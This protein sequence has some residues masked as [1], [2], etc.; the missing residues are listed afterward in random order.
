[1]EAKR[2]V[3]FALVEREAQ[4]EAQ[5]AHGRVVAQAKAQ[6]VLQLEAQIGRLREDVPC[7]PEGCQA[8][9]AGVAVA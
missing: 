7:V 4:V 1:M 9:A 2:L 6:R 8:Q 5:Q 3:A